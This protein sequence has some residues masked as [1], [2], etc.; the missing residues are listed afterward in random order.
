VITAGQRLQ[1]A[2]S[3]GIAPAAERVHGVI[4]AKNFSSFLEDHNEP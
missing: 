4:Y 3:E 1:S 2:T